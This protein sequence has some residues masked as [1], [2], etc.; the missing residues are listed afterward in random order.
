M[1]TERTG[2]A[3]E[4]AKSVYDRLK[5]DRAP[6]ETRAENCAKVTIPSLFPKEADNASTDYTTPWQAV[7]ARGLNNLSAKVMLALFPLQS[8]MKLR[9]SEWQAK[10]L[11]AD[12][13]QL[14]QVE[15]GLGMVERILMAYMEANAYRVTLFELIRQL[16]LCGNG[17]IYL[18]PPDATSSAYNPM[19]LYTLHNYVCQRDAFGNVLQIVTL[20]R[21][22]YAALPEDVRS[23]LDGEHKPDEEIEVYTHVYLDDESGDYLSYQE[24]DDEEVEGTD[25]QYPGDACP[26]V[27]VRWTKRD[28]EHYG[29][30]HVEEY[31][32]DLNSL[33]NLHEAMIKFSMIA[34]KVITLVNPNGMT[35][36]RRLVKAQS[37]DMVPGRKQD[38]E[39][40]QLEKTADFSVAKSV[41]DNIEQRLS[42]VFMLNSAIQ[43]GGERV[44]AEEI[45]YMAQELEDTLGGVYS[46]LSQELQLPMVRILLNQLQATQQIPDMPKEA[47]EPTV[48]TGVEALGRGQDL[49]KLTQFMQMMQM[50]GAI[51]G[52]P[53]LNVA[54]LKLRAANAIGLDTSGLLLTEADKAKAL[55]QNMLEQGGAAA[56]QGIG[57]GVAQQA[58]ASPEAMQ[59]AMDTAGVQAGPIPSA[60]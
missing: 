13:A 49:D 57:A 60:G 9:I 35:Q 4:S 5:S 19:K 21:V 12:P 46:I 45:R 8:W 20:D 39:F 29:R 27:A 52:D 6:Y 23:K 38:I 59:G 54:N 48:S 56:A 22:A 31:L 51:S 43:R 47:V 36:V 18:P 25:G 33:E 34:A 10:Q 30:S 53:D 42:F 16:A 24:I 44:T 7:G 15:Q 32:G 2:L 14:A 50:M 28:G 58:T 1:A 41:A 37:G 40:L 17:C 55:G 3:E 11:V 26:W